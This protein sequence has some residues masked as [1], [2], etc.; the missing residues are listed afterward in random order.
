MALELAVGAGVA[1][2]LPLLIHHVAFGPGHRRQITQ[3]ERLAIAPGDVVFLGDSI[4]EAV[5]WHELFPAISARNRGIGGDTVEEIESRLDPIVRGHPRKLFL[6]AGTNDVRMRIPVEHSLAAYERMLDRIRRESPE[7]LVFVE[8][9][10]PRSERYAPRIRTFNERLRAVATRHGA[11]WLDWFDA[12]AD[13]RGV[14]RPAYSND[15]LH[16]LG[17]G[18]ELWTRLLAPYVTAPTG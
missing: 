1:F 14:I 3:F 15:D 13:E 5:Q 2:E 10:L 12:F 7:T 6:M 8:G 9:V 4:T 17:P 16:L 11:T 18:I